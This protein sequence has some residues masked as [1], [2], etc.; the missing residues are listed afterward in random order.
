MSKRSRLPVFILAAVLLPATVFLVSC[1]SKNNPADPGDTGPSVLITAPSAGSNVSGVGFYVTGSV[2]AADSVTT[3][4]MSAGGIVFDSTGVEAGLPSLPFSFFV[5]AVLFADGVELEVTVTGVDKEGNTGSR[6]VTVTAGQRVFSTIGRIG[7]QERS[8]SWSPDGNRIAYTSEGN[9][10]TQ[11][12]Y[13]VAIDGSD[14]LQITTDVNNDIAPAYSAD[15]QEIAFASDRSGNW[16]IWNVSAAGGTPVAITTNGSADR[17]PSWS[18]DGASIAFHSIRDANWNIYTVP[19]AG[20][21]AAGAPVAATSLTSA[22][23]SAVW[24]GDENRLVF[25]SNQSISWDIWTVTP[26]GM[27]MEVVPYANDPSVLE[28]DPSW[29]RLGDYLLIADNRNGSANYDIWA[30]HPPS[31]T[32]Q[33]LTSNSAPDREPVWSR[34]GRKIAYASRQNGTWDIWIIE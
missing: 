31:G 3:V 9:G 8:P 26:P 6:S 34:D 15:G 32:K 5:P 4:R 2:A 29:S 27:T 24:M 13:T 7:D 20:G 18:P 17:G 11:D 23:S 28:H 12:I 14:T 10:G 22:E 25:A 33:L 16:D 21:V 1:G 19:V 30:V